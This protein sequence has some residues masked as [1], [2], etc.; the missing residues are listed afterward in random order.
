MKRKYYIIKWEAIEADEPIFEKLAR[1]HSNDCSEWA[2][3]ND[4][5]EAMKRI[6]AITGEKVMDGDDPF[7]VGISGLYDENNKVVFEL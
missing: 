4:Y 5:E 7:G 1:C 6:E 3:E 2:N